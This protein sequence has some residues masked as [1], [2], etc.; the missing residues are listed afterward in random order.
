MIRCTGYHWTEKFPHHRDGEVGFG[1]EM[2]RRSP[3]LTGTRTMGNLRVQKTVYKLG[4]LMTTGTLTTVQNIEAVSAK[5]TI[6]TVCI[7]L[8]SQLCFNP[9]PAG[10]AYIRVFLFY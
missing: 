5:R 7:L 1:L 6:W 3:G 8:S 10:A 2:A 4:T 9:L